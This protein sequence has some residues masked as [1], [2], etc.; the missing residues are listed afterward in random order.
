[1]PRHLLLS[2]VLVLAAISL[3]GAGVA[4]DLPSPDNSGAANYRIP[5][6]P[7]LPKRQI[8]AGRRSAA[9]RQLQSELQ[10]KARPEPPQQP[11]EPPSEQP[12]P[13]MLPLSGFVYR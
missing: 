13:T 4:A 6:P 9:Q 8:E 2:A 12:E 11:A 3:P 10:A 7:D 5:V 1:M